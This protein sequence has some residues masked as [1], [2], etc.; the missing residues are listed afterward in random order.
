MREKAKTTVW[1][2]RRERSHGLEIPPDLESEIDDVPI[3]PSRER[4]VSGEISAAR[5]LADSSVRAYAGGWKRFRAWCAVNQLPDLPAA[6]ERVAAFLTDYAETGVKAAT[7]TKWT[8]AIAHYHHHAGY[9]SPTQTPHVRRT[10]R[11]LRRRFGSAQTQKAPLLI[12][13]LREALERLPETIIGRRDAALL[14]LGFAGAFRRSELVALEVSDIAEGAAGDNRH[15]SPFQNRPGRQR[16]YSRYPVRA[17]GV[18]LSRAGGAAVAGHLRRRVRA[19]S[20]LGGQAR[21]RRQAGDA[22]GE[23]RRHRETCGGLHRP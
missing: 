9:E 11:L 19:A 10:L 8:A 15:A 4:E 21:Q 5:L 3:A 13:D 20:A 18:D 7:L 6:P 1:S 16:V 22:P 12:D 17:S 2:G 23:R 14:L